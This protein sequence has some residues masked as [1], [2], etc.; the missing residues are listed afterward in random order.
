V[1]LA[2]EARQPLA[3]RAEADAEAGGGQALGHADAVVAHGE[4]QAIAV[5][6][7]ADRQQAAPLQALQ[8]VPQRV[9]D[10][11]LEDEGR[12]QRVLRVRRDVDRRR[13]PIAEAHL[14]DREVGLRQRDFGPPAPPKDKKKPFKKED[15]P[16]GP[17][18][19][20][21]SGRMYDLDGTEDEDTIDITPDFM[22]HED[23]DVDAAD[24][25]ETDKD[26]E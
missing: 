14:L 24:D 21:F 18:P 16:R 13:Q 20:K 12:D 4:H 10:D 6:G 2:V 23:P 25:K 3:G 9:L 22:K 26:K 8:P 17:I 15:K 1:R 7:A 19:T 5:A 11:G